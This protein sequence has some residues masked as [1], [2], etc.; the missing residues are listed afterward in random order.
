MAAGKEKLMEYMN[1]N[2]IVKAV[3]GGIYYKSQNHVFSCVCTDT[4]KI[5]KN[6]IFFALHGEKFN[7]N[8]FIV[9]ASNKG[10]SICIVDEIKFDLHDINQNT[11]IIKVN[12]TIEALAELAAFYRRKL[13]I[14]IIGVTG[15]TG[16][17]STKDILAAVLSKK[18]KVFKT[19]ENFNNEIGL[20][21]MVFKLDRSYD[22]AILEMG[23]SNFNEI[24]KLAYITRPDL[25]IIT[26]IGISHIENLKTREN[27]L[28][29]KLEITDYFT[30]DN[31]LIING[32]NDLLSMYSSDKFNVVK[33]GIDNQCDFT[34]KDICIEEQ[35]VKYKIAER[36]S[37]FISPEFKINLP[38]KHIVYNS[39]LA[40]ACGRILN[41]NYS[42]IISGLEN[43]EMTAMRLDIV[44]CGNFILIDDCYNASPDSMKAAIDVL[45]NI[46]A[47]TRIAILGT[48]KE[49]GDEG[50]NAHV[51]VGRYAKEKGI[52]N[53]IVTG[54][55]SEA[56]KIGYSD[57][58]NGSGSFI[59]IDDYDHIVD[60]AKKILRDN[61]C[62][63]VKA[64]HSMNFEIIVQKLKNIQ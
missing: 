3:E 48:M 36:N 6:S 27:I 47:K 54:E 45:A 2:E 30:K 12:D 24:H 61:A 1:F 7:G 60:Y 20:P 35:N 59:K 21:L 42:D 16:K 49:L 25:A 44:K 10:A 63:L 14:K 64:S 4:R 53:L 13:N 38:G 9:D 56:Y 62:V 32:D 33:I 34:A 50:F 55:F 22:I 15:S 8:D 23:M 46:H 11:S 26:N 58:D 29:A 17:T 43:L 39:L 31:V 18:Y 52:D 51:E 37:D 19:E 41:I 57:G 40:I 5:E 28:K